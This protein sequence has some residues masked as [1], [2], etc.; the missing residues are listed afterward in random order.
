M[1][2]PPTF[3]DWNDHYLKGLR[4]MIE[5]IDPSKAQENLPGIKLDS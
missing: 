2:L 3:V 5:G 4:E 1:R